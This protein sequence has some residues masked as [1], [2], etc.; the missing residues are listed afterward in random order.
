MARGIRARREAEPASLGASLF[1]VQVGGW[2]ELAGL[3][4]RGEEGKLSNL[5]DEEERFWL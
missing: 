5:A 4:G 1:P 3:G 2:T